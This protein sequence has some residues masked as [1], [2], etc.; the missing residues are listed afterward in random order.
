M[1]WVTIVSIEWV[2]RGSGGCGCVVLL[3]SDGKIPYDTPRLQS[4]NINM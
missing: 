2:G 4:F 1:G 3:S